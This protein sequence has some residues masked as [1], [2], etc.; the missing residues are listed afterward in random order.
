MR[1]NTMQTAEDEDDMQ[2]LQ[3]VTNREANQNIDGL[4]MYF[5][6]ES[7]EG[8]HIAAHIKHLIAQ[9]SL[10]CKHLKGLNKPHLVYDVCFHQ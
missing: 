10:G 1:Q 5:T 2:E 4:K 9:I 7:N 6:Q 3:H 8:S